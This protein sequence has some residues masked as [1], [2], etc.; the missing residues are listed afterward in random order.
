MQKNTTSYS[1]YI[2]SSAWRERR[3][4]VLAR[5]KHRCRACGS[6]DSLHVHHRTYEHFMAEPYEDLVALCAT[7][8]EWVHTLQRLG[9]E[10]GAATD[11]I[12][13]LGRLPTSPIARAEF[14][15]LL[16]RASIDDAFADVR[17]HQKGDRS[18]YQQ[19]P[20]TRFCRRCHR[21]LPFDA[22]TLRPKKSCDACERRRTGPR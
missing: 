11:E 2:A 13:R 5:D 10:L 7:C 17:A 18:V 6:E 1:A 9:W 14:E 12:M 22:F 21:W 4:T 8:H 3:A 19:R 15:V 20:A 16:G